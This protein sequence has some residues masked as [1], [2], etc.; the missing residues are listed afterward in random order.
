MDVE[1]T[2]TFLATAASRSIQATTGR[3]TMSVSGPDSG[4]VTSTSEG[5]Y[6]TR[7]GRTSVTV[8]LGG[9]AAG[10]SAD[11]ARME[12]V[13]DGSTA[14]LRSPALRLVL[15]TEKW[16]RLDAADLKGVGAGEDLRVLTDPPTADLDLLRGAT[17]VDETGHERVR[18]TKTTRMHAVVDLDAAIDA[19]P[20]D[21]RP[22]LRTARRTL[23]S[24][25]VKTVPVDVWIGG[26]GLV[27]RLRL[28][29]S[30]G[31]G[32]RAAVTI[33]YYGYGD[34]VR[35]EPPSGDEVS[36]VSPERLL[37]GMDEGG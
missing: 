6:D 2:P 15:G 33:D 16:V 36:K 3:F 7:T 1:A 30:A 9:D 5:S 22:L 17:D 12:L 35:I 18:G 13:V 11:A 26:D 21:R 29:A 27:R 19:T 14:F 23:A 28:T 32:T 31:S 10:V 8:R 34:H 4:G 24:G 25:G 20:E 37:S